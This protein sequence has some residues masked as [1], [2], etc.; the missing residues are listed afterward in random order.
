MLTGLPPFYNQNLHLMYERIVRARVSYPP[1]LSHASKSLLSALLERE[2][3]RRLGSAGD[4]AEVKAH[5]FFAAIDWAKLAR[6]EVQAPFV[7][8]NVEGK[9]DTSNVDEEFTRETPRDTPIIT[10]NLRPGSGGQQVSFPGFTYNPPSHY[11]PVDPS[12]QSAGGW[13]RDLT[14]EGVE[15]NHGQRGGGDAHS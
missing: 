2:P 8:T 12:G 5:P 3:E 7:P 10:S 14:E 13:R 4:A 9:A 1:Y 15:S 11:L 6:R